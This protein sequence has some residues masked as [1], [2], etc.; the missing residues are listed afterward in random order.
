M[1]DEY[2]LKKKTSS[3]S[4][5]AKYKSFRTYTK[6]ILKT[7][8]I[9]SFPEIATSKSWIKRII[10]ITVFIMCLI[11]FTYQTLD[12]LWMYLGYPTVVNVFVSNPYEIMQPAVTVCNKNRRRRSYI[13]S[14]PDIL[15]YYVEPAKFC[16]SYPVLC[17]GNDPKR[18]YTLIPYVVSLAEEEYDWEATFEESHNETIIDLCETRIEEKTI[19]CNNTKRIPVIDAKGEPNT[20]VTIDSLVGQPNAEDTIY[21]NTYILELHMKTQAEEYIR[22]TDPLMLQILI[23]NRRALVNPF[24][25]GSSLQAG[26][27]YNAFVSQVYT[28]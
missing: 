8:L 19:R 25:E 10:K 4:N 26:G 24:S 16:K 17:P 27:Q 20:C 22:F 2:P 6:T 11:G 23:H 3:Q 1:D 21:P 9:T 15:C 7:S 28:I 14:Q 5:Y 13:C 18:A 12:F